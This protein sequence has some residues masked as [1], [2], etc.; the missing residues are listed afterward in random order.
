MGVARIV[1]GTART[2]IKDHRIAVAAE[3]NIA[4]IGQPFG[5]FRCQKFPH[6]DCRRG[7][8]EPAIVEQRD[9]AIGMGHDA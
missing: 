1:I 9:V 5:F 8:S 7:L 2:A 4:G 6:P 3:P